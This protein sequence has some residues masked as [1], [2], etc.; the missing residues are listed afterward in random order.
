MNL[1]ANLAVNLGRNHE[2][3]RDP[4][5]AARRAQ[6]NERPSA[7]RRRQIG[8]P[9]DHTMTCSS[10]FIAWSKRIG[11]SE[12]APSVM[13]IEVRS[14]RS[15]RMT[16]QW[17]EVRSAVSARHNPDQT[18]NA[19]IVRSNV[20]VMTTAGA[21]TAD[22]ADVL[23]VIAAATDR[24]PNRE[25]IVAS[26]VVD[27][28]DETG[29]VAAVEAVVSRTAARNRAARLIGISTV[30]SSAATI[31]GVIAG[32]TGASSAVPSWSRPKVR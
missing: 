23:I 25:T 1:A 32:S 5:P 18:A 15:V 28:A 2:A 13:A 16:E 7:R 21:T 11:S 26:A 29:S 8:R 17:S 24:M 6:L 10:V 20:T 14:G 3:N 22:V 27:A 9:S 12:S 19:A 30:P 31:V 4:T